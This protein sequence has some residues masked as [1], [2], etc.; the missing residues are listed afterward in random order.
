M[1]LSAD[2]PGWMD[3][4]KASRMVQLRAL[5]Y[6]QSE[7]AAQLDVS[8]QTVSKYLAV[9]NERAKSANDPT[10]FLWGLLMIGAGVAL[11]GS[12]LRALQGENR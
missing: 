9:V 1:E 11:L 6:N 10:Q 12:L 3:Q 2:L 5:G 4:Y 7:I 8:Q